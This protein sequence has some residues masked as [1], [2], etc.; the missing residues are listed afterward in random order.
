[1][2][3]NCFN[4]LNQPVP[5]PL[6]VPNSVLTLLTHSV[7]R[8]FHVILGWKSWEWL[9]SDDITYPMP[10]SIWGSIEHKFPTW[11]RLES[12]IIPYNLVLYHDVFV[13]KFESHWLVFFHGLMGKVIWQHILFYGLLGQYWMSYSD[14]SICQWAI[15][16]VKA[17]FSNTYFMGSIF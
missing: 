5:V 15:L 7:L 1:M 11:S 10:Q 2:N 6:T 9:R 8:H 12:F 16:P 13:W 3:T 17:G 14:K 4:Q